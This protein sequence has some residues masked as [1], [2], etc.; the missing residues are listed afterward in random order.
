M[1][2]LF[3]P[4]S[5]KTIE[6]KLRRSEQIKKDQS[7]QV[8]IKQKEGRLIDPRLLSTELKR[9]TKPTLSKKKQRRFDARKAAYKAIE[10]KSVKNEVRA[11]S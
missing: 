1:K 7:K 4:L 6:Q 8:N 10:K 5:R 2:L 3:K 9:R 11:C